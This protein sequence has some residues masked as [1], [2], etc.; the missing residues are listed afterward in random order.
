MSYVIKKKQKN[1]ELELLFDWIY[2]Y[3][4]NCERKDLGHPN[5]KAHCKIIIST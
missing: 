5:S 4:D 2:Q 3:N 1:I